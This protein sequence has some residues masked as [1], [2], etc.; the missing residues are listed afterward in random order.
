VLRVHARGAALVL[1]LRWSTARP[2][3][4]YARTAAAQRLAGDAGVPVPAVVTAGDD[5]T[6]QHLLQEHVDGA[7]WRQVRPQLRPRELAAAS[8]QIAEAVLALQSVTLPAFGALDEPTGGSVLDALRARV[9]LRIPRAAERA[10]ALDV[11]AGHA[12]L[13][14]SQPDATL[15]HDDLHHANVLFRRDAS[16][17]RLAAMLD[18]DKAWAGP[19]ESDVARMAFWDDMTDP[20]FWSVY[21]AGRAQQ[22]GWEERA[23]IYQLLW[24]LE[25][26]VTTR[27]HRRDTA[28]LLARLR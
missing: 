26:D 20:S 6:V 9:A 16:R 5:G 3:V 24:C 7:E 8:A 25:Y 22:D 11:L 15:T 10:V 21:R 17:W 14:A 18:W 19:P 13:F 1:K 2:T 23:R 27:R 4:D 12:G 28:D